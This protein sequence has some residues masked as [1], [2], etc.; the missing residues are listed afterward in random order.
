M[1]MVNSQIPDAVDALKAGF[2]DA[3]IVVIGGRGGIG[4]EVV[5]QAHALGAIVVIGSSSQGSL[6]LDR[7]ALKSTR[8]GTA[9]IDLRDPAS[10]SQFAKTVGD[11]LG[12]V[13]ILVNTAGS[14]I[15][16][17]FEDLSDEIIAE[18][19]QTNAMGV[20][21]TIR[22]FTPLLKRGRDPV[23]VNIGSVAAKTGGGSNIAYVGAKA[24]VDAMAIGLA[25]TLAPEIRV[26]GIAPSALETGF[27]KGR[28][29]DFLKATQE[30][31]PLKRITHV[32]EV[33][34]AV[35]VAA[36]VLTAT[37]GVSIAVDGG[38]HL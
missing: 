34:N 28:A 2:K 21:S 15:Q 26:V 19:F 8:R 24:A 13:D 17:P 12:R 35:L 11:A 32:R 20:L 38:R 18:V 6:E 23:I 25:K 37:T 22:A 5:E 4:A 31:T 9:H 29:P 1:T 16:K 27:A 33:A 10:I 7:E 3:V 30:A 36:R 14:S